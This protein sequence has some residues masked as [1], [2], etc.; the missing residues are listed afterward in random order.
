MY[1]IAMCNRVA[2]D[3]VVNQLQIS[4]S[5]THEIICD[6]LYFHK[7]YAKMGSKTTVVLKPIF[8]QTYV[9]MVTPMLFCELLT[10]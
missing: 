6:R 1:Y 8:A 10:E 5:S 2:I 9:Q 7:V 3:E 4:H